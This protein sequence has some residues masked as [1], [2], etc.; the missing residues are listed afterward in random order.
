MKPKTK[1]S[2]GATYNS[3]A[4]IKKMKGLETSK[5][6]NQNVTTQHS[7]SKIRVHSKARKESK[8]KQANQRR[9]VS[10][11][12]RKQG[13]TVL[14]SLSSGTSSLI[15]VHGGSQTAKV[16]GSTIDNKK[17]IS[18]SI[19]RI[20]NPTSMRGSSTINEKQA[21][22]LAMQFKSA[23]ATNTDMG[24]RPSSI[25]NNLLQRPPPAHQSSNQ[26]VQGSATSSQVKNQMTDSFNIYNKKGGSIH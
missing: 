9:D 2:M 16:S 5:Y 19:E 15:Y 4:A 3:I 23:S 6:A 17:T 8:P 7:Q 21:Q 10:N 26:H 20:S 24:I 18:N 12:V 11:H 22:K 14:K 1:K 13:S 25:L